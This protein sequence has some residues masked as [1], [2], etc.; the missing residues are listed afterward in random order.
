MTTLK[1]CLHTPPRGRASPIHQFQSFCEVERM[2]ELPAVVIRT[3]PVEELLKN[4]QSWG[5]FGVDWVKAWAP[6]LQKEES[7]PGEI[8][9]LDVYAT[10]NVILSTLPC[11]E[12]VLYFSYLFKDFFPVDSSDFSRPPAGRQASSLAFADADGWACSLCC[13]GAVS[14]VVFRRFLERG[15]AINFFSGYLAHAV[16]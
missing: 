2:K 16:V 11:W 12:A 6:H 7:P 4:I 15:V 10:G 9:I 3:A 14:V 1:I 5:A 13:G 8:Q